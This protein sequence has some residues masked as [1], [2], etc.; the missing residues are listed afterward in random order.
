VNRATE[1]NHRAAERTDCAGNA[2][3]AKTSAAGRAVR[4]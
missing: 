3:P 2:V 4:Y 1:S